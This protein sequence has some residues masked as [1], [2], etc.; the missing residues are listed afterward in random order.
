MLTIT[1][2][3][4]LARQIRNYLNQTKFNGFNIEFLEMSGLWT[5]KFSIKGERSILERIANDIKK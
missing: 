4:L 3:R 5:F 1:T 2:N